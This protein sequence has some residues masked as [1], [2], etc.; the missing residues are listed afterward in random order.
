MKGQLSF[1]AVILLNLP[2][3]AQVDCLQGDCFNGKGTCLFPSG[4]KYV[5]EFSQGKIHGEGTLY[6]SNGN[7]YIGSWVNQYREGQGKL[8]FEGGDVYEGA[9][10]RN[11]FQGEGTMNYANGNR[12]VGRWR[13][14]QPDG[15]GVFYYANGDRY[16]GNFAEGQCSGTG[17]LFYN[18]GAR[19]AGQW[20]DNKPHGEGVLYL[21]NGE[22]IAG[23]WEG[24]QY[25]T[26]WS[27][28]AFSGDTSYL[29]DCNR[30]PC[31]TLG[32]YRYPDG[33]VYTGQFSHGRP[34]GKASV[35][36]DNGDRYEGLWAN[37]APQGRG[38]MYYATGKILGAYWESG[39]PA[40]ELFA[41]YEAERNPGPASTN[42][43][44]IWA[45][46][47]GAAHYTH[48]PALRY[49]DDDAYQLYAF[50]KSPEGGAL[51]DNQLRLLVDEDASK[52]NIMEAMRNTFSKADDNDVLLFYFSGHGLKGAFLPTDYDGHNN[53][54]EHE[55]IKELLAQSRAKH[56]LVLAD[57]C[58]S[59]SL[60]EY[61]SNLN[62][63]LEKYYKAFNETPGGTA[64]LMSSKGEEYSLEDGGLR[65]GIFSHFLV[66]GLKGAADNDGNRI[67]NIGELFDYVHQ[68]VR[69]YT[70]N[71]QTP[72]LTGEFDRRMPVSVVR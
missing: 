20:S 64:L 27:G 47:I 28:L 13:D 52:R 38:V 39:Q 9:F 4:A 33:T 55:S 18:S 32:K 58:H 23:R 7:K 21:P 56:K 15:K 71:V 63:V 22:T 66:R 12:Y 34:K 72:T 65:S 5:G 10:R 70:G 40:Y 17:T 57:A 11:A 42:N 43:V 25:Q 8:I 61:K 14:N 31:A 54:L 16:E 44:K 60:Y 41:R 3:F 1:L 59:G 62:I 2:L 53:R 51:P 26:D 36:Y 49:T 24:G 68:K 6:F 45:V 48:M 67:V 30:A 37:D 29:K 46:V 35:F 50:L 19:Y 69:M